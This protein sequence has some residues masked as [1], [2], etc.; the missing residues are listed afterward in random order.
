MI[1]ND[2]MTS[3]LHDTVIIKCHICSIPDLIQINWLRHQQILMDVNIIIKTQTIDHYQ[4]SQSIMEIVVRI[5]KIFFLF[6]FFKMFFLF[7]FK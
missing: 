2:K 5:F 6:F 4:C 7:L 3:D 1:L